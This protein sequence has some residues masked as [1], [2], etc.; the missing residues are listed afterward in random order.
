MATT[1]ELR[2]REIVAEGPHAVVL[3]LD[4]EEHHFAYQAGQAVW[5]GRPGRAKRS[6]Y[7]IACAPGRARA[8]RNLEFLIRTDAHARVG[9]HLDPLVPGSVIAVEGPLGRFTLRPSADAPALLFVAGGVG[10]APLRAMIQEALEQ[11]EP[12]N[13][14]LLHSARTPHDFAFAAEFDALAAAGLMRVVRTATRGIGPGTSLTGRISGDLLASLN[15]QPRTRCY[16]CGPE[17]LV[18]DVSSLLGDQGVPL[19]RIVR[20]DWD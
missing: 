9:E 11:L 13:M 19:D 2:V 20:D 10:I 14:T 7:S 17:E 15:L 8:S 16:V 18:G 3:R 12:P 1:L 5:L 4:L 6:A